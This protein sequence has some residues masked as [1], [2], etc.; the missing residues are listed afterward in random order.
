MYLDYLSVDTVPLRH[1]THRPLSRHFLL[2]HTNFDIAMAQANLDI[3]RVRQAIDSAQGSSNGNLSDED[4]RILEAA[5]AEI[6]RCIQARP[7][8]YIC[9][10][11]E[12]RV[13]N[14]YQERFKNNSVAA[15]AKKR[16]WN[17]FSSTDGPRRR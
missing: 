15:K 8:T 14:Y 13:F 11:L 4:S 2:P 17:H 10:Q 5:L 16:Y 9:T 7:D 6:W 12:F 3:P 1:V